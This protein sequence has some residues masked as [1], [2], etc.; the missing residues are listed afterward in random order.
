[1]DN[2]QSQH[3]ICATCKFHNAP[4]LIEPALQ[5]RSSGIMQVK[6]DW[7]M[8]MQDIKL[9][10]EDAIKRHKYLNNKPR[11]LH[12]CSLHSYDATNPVTGEKVR[13]YAI[14][15]HF[16]NPNIECGA[17]SPVDSTV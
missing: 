2:D 17:Y 4:N 3:P 5:G 11:T 7:K 9:F 1:M 6:L 16:N 14:C 13:Q 12:W 8:K 10:E 15:K